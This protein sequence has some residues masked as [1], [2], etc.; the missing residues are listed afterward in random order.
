M[1]MSL[2]IRSSYGYL[3]L[4]EDEDFNWAG[5]W[6]LKA[7][8]KVLFFIW[9]AL[10]A[11]IPTLDFLQKRG[12]ILPNVCPLRQGDTESVDHTQLHCPFTCEIWSSILLEANITW[13][14]PGCCPSFFEQW[15][16]PSKHCKGRIL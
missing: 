12:F 8:S 11:R 4:R 3:E 9:T 10:N 5:I 15:L 16:S 2:L 6:K 13:V 7:H 1:Q 14:V